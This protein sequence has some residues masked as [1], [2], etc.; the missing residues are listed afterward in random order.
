MSEDAAVAQ[1]AS[2]PSNDTT[3][4]PNGGHGGATSARENPNDE[5]IEDGPAAKR[6]KVDNNDA[7]GR[8]PMR[9]VAPIKAE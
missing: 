8:P 3:Q 9:G 6:V 7:S 2:L 4:P 1:A 5:L